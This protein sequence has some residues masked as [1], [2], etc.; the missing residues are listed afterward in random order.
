MRS[1]AERLTPRERDCL[2]L[3]AQHFT[4]KG[5]ARQL[6]LSQHTVDGHFQEA[7]RKLGAPTRRDAV[8][9]FLEMEG[10]APPRNWGGQSSGGSGGALPL[11]DQSVEPKPHSPDANDSPEQGGASLLPPNSGRGH[12]TAVVPIPEAPSRK[13]STDGAETRDDFKD[14]RPEDVLERPRLSAAAVPIPPQLRAARFELSPP[15]RLAAIVLIAVVS[16]PLLLL[17]LLGAHELTFAIQ[18]VIEGD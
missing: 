10:D 2:Q 6:G 18:R 8:R 1:V 14:V 13:P 9:I 11:A 3:A 15:Q 17:L 16:A 5:I 4:S 7:R 12:S